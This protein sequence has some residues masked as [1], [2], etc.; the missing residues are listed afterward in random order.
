MHPSFA[1]ATNKGDQIN[2]V[3]LTINNYSPL[4]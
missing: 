1:G 3:P 4:R 2:N